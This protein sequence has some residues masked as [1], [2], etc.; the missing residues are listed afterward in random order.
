LYHA[1]L[2]NLDGSLTD[3]GSLSPYYYS[4]AFA[5]NDAGLVVGESQINDLGTTGQRHA[6]IWNGSAMLDLNDLIQPFG[7]VLYG[8][9]D[10]N[11]AGQ[12]V[13]WGPYPGYG[14]AGAFLLTPV[15]EP[16]TLMLLSA[17]LLGILSRRRRGI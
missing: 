9:T 6:F 10:I 15:P 13:A 3:L 12:I 7:G 16:V 17:G 5:I 2:W 11:S 8:A 4:K 1:V 14:S